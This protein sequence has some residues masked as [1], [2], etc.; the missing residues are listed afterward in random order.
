[1]VTAKIIANTLKGKHSLPD[2]KVEDIPSKKSTKTARPKQGRKEAKENKRAGELLEQGLSNEEIIKSL[3]EEFGEVSSSW[4]DYP[5]DRK[6]AAAKTVL[7][8]AKRK[9][10]YKNESKQK[11][12]KVRK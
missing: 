6:Q 12:R 9:I 1:M 10:R 3:L 5:E 2:W 4:G 11:V 7:E 8:S